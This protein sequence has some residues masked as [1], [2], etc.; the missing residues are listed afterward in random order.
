M[1]KNNRARIVRTYAHENG[2]PYSRARRELDGQRTR[3]FDEH[4]TW[5]EIGDPTTAS[6]IAI[7]TVLAD[8]LRQWLD[9]DLSPVS[10]VVLGGFPYQ[11]IQCSN[12]ERFRVVVGEALEALDELT[13][14]DEDGAATTHRVGIVERFEVRM[15]WA[16]RCL[17]GGAAARFATDMVRGRML[18]AAARAAAERSCMLAQLSLSHPRTSCWN[19]S[20]VPVRLAVY[21]TAGHGEVPQMITALGCLR[22]A[23]EEYTARTIG[24]PW[25][26]LRIEGGTSDDHQTIRQLAR[27]IL[28]HGHT[29]TP[30]MAAALKPD[31]DR[32][33]LPDPAT[34]R[35]FTCPHCHGSGHFAPV[36]G[37]AER[38]GYCAP[39][40]A[41]VYRVAV[42]AAAI[43]AAITESGSP[44]QFRVEAPATFFEGGPYGA[45]T[46]WL[47]ARYF[48]SLI[49][50]PTTAEHLAGITNA[51]TDEDRELIGHLTELA[52]ALSGRPATPRTPWPTVELHPELSP[53]QMKA[54]QAA[55]TL[56]GSVRA[57]ADTLCARAG[58]TDRPTQARATAYLYRSLCGT[59][60]FLPWS[61]IDFG[62]PDTTAE[63]AWL[64]GRFTELLGEPDEFVIDFEYNLAARPTAKQAIGWLCDP[65]DPV[66][67]VVSPSV[68]TPDGTRL[69]DPFVYTGRGALMTPALPGSATVRV[70][71]IC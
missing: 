41:G 46:V 13:E 65:A 47:F 7:A 29:H 8:R 16:Q 35:W 22:H 21:D 57:L 50:V 34:V 31:L 49:R 14:P 5:H 6:V 68:T 18:G 52:I 15:V 9:T 61:S 25:L 55:G 48:Q 42:D 59:E 62:D 2:I 1:T 10:A 27:E 40:P 67:L 56:L 70:S 4:G 39:T 3:Y 26:Q 20:P 36:N 30:R 12:A 37:P 17:R 19:A 32:A 64:G 33:Q 60:G 58:H 53:R 43:H 38:C 23:A 51:R 45:V 24:E 44:G 69:S 63:A 11:I 66:L 54:S 28:R 71:P